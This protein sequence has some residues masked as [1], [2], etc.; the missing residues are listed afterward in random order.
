MSKTAVDEPRS[1]QN[2]SAR[3]DLPSRVKAACEELLTIAEQRFKPLLREVLDSYENALFGLA[4]KAADNAEQQRQFEA[5]HQ[6]KLGRKQVEPGFLQSLDEDVARLRDDASPVAQA[7]RSQPELDAEPLELVESEELDEELAL[8]DIA[9]RAEVRH[10]EALYLLAH[11]IAVLDAAPVL[12]N[13]ELP[14]GPARLCDAFRGALAP[15][16]L[17]VAARLLA[18]RQFE[19]GL[20]RALGDFYAAL[21]ESLAQQRI[22][23]N[24][25]FR[26]ASYRRAASGA[27]SANE[28]PTDGTPPAE[29]DPQPEKGA[30]AP[31]PAQS[32][33]LSGTAAAVLRAAAGLLPKAPSSQAGIAPRAAP[34]RASS[35][36]PGAAAAASE[37]SDLYQNL[38]GLIR[39]HRQL[40]S[41]PSGSAPAREAASTSELQDLLDGLQR[42]PATAAGVARHDSEFLKNALLVKLRRTSPT[43]HPRTLGESDADTVDLVGMLFD[44]IANELQESNETRSLLSRLHIPVLRVALADQTFFTRQDHPARE[45]LNTIGEASTRW[46]DDSDTDL[47][48]KMQR[49]VDQVVSDFN[50]DVSVFAKLLKDLTQYMQTLARRAELSERRLIEAARGR[51]RF[52][53]ASSTAKA[54]VQRILNESTP[55]PFVK[56]LLERAWTDALALSALRHGIA[57]DEYQRAVDAAKQLATDRSAAASDEKLRQTLDS[58]LRQIGLH[59]DDV[60]NVFDGLSVPKEKAENAAENLDAALEAHPRLGGQTKTPPPA[61]PTE[62]IPLGEREAEQLARLRRTPFGTWFEFISN[63]QGDR[64]RQKLAWYSPVSGRCLFVNQRGMHASDRTLNQLARDMVREQAFIVEETQSGSFIDR[65]LAVVAA[66]LRKSLSPRRLASG[67]PA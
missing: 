44:H 45:L 55:D 7:A 58:G 22:L 38:L 29:I 40:D 18:Y 8:R 15:C 60:R 39:Q 33:G 34:S 25:K 52:E 59:K 53:A 56:T 42:S 67:A 46:A 21:N 11:R 5:L 12:A 19:Q 16:R 47:I 65:A 17:T 57:S 36:P 30:A 1:G 9:S 26:S 63:Q 62:S 51:D 3:S 66:K 10:S 32:A 31:A 64:T 43:G 41:G 35:P 37:A 24:L 49:L 48:G 4:E 50:G 2:L 6:I 61:Q 20:S 27:A 23:P 28:T 13:D 54:D 14:F